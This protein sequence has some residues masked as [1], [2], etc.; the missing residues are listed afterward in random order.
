MCTVALAAIDASASGCTGVCKL[1][2]SCP[3]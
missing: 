1:W 3:R 2:P